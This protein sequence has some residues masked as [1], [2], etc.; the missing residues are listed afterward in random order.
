MDE[1]EHILIVDDEREICEVVREYLADEGYRV[2]AAPN[3]GEMRRILGES[4]VDIV[5]L[6]VMLPGED[7]FALARWLQA[8]HP[9]LGIIMLTGRGDTID[10]IVGLELGADDYLAKPFHLRELLARIRSIARRVGQAPADPPATPR[11]QVR[12]AGWSLDLAARE[13]F[14][15]EGE[16]VRLTAGEFD[17]LA[18]FVTHGN[19]L[20][21]RD[22]LL[23]L[24][25]G[26]EAGPFDRTI[27]VQV[28]RLR[29][30]LGDD[31]QEPKLIKTLRGGGYIFVA[32]IERVHAPPARPQPPGTS[33]AA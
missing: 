7:G 3:G 15:P 31:A 2:S 27:D 16:S 10:R 21:S 18:A 11:R 5:L 6:D 19:Q 24:A 13:L 14:S 20:L 29:R 30:K 28:G 25:R 32:P 22:R 12:F 26:R 4:P 17:L 1:N 33:A 9:D 23:D 8:E